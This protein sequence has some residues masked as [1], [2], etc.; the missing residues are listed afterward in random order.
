MYREDSKR[1][2]GRFRAWKIEE[3]DIWVTDGQKER[4]FG[5]PSKFPDSAQSTDRE[6]SWISDIFQQLCSGRIADALLTEIVHPTVP[7]SRTDMF[8][9]SRA[10]EICGLFNKGSL[11]VTCIEEF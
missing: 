1:W 10:R 5:R 7:R 11:K 9:P 2:D 3:K 8:D 6:L 4:K